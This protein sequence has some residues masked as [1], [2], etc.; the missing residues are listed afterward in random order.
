MSVKFYR[1]EVL[2]CVGVIV[3]YRFNAFCMIDLIIIKY[4]TMMKIGFY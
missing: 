2:F 4:F 3:G 1:V